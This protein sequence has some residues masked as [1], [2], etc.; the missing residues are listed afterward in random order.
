MKVILSIKPEFADKIFSGIKK[1]EFRRAL[2]KNKDVKTILVYSSSP[3][4][5]IIGEFEI[6]KILAE[7][8]DTLWSKTKDYSGISREYFD[9]YFTDKDLGY[10]IEVKKVKRY[11]TP[12][13]I[14]SDYNMLPPQSFAYLA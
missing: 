5:K 13:C 7:N 14:K 6:E 11:K 4:Q 12:K 10:A 3:V 1:F 9:A 8:P 2:F